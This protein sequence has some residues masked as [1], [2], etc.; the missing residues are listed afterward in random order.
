M[1]VADDGYRKRILPFL[2]KSLLE[3]ERRSLRLKDTA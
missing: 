3:R 1:V 2:E